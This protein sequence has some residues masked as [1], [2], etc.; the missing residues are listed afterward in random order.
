MTGTLI[1]LRAV[2]ERIEE[3]EDTAW[4]FL[5]AK[6]PWQITSSAAVLQ[7]EEVPPELED[8]SEAGIPELAKTAGLMPV[9]PI[10][11]VQEVVANARSQRP[12][13]D[14]PLLFDALLHYYDHDAFKEL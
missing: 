7:M 11:T 14:V 4:L 10:S 2:L 9:L 6:E 13:V 1:T 5:P 12:N 3:L 8:D